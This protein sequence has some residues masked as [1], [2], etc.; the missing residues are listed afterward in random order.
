MPSPNPPMPNNVTQPEHAPM[1]TVSPQAAAALLESQ[2]RRLVETQHRF[3][4]LLIGPS[5]SM[6]TSTALLTA[7]WP[8]MVYSFDPGG[9][10]GSHLRDRIVSPSNPDAP[11]W[12]N[13][14]F[15]QDSPSTPVAFE[16]F[17]NDLRY[18]IAS[19]TFRLFNTL[20]LDSLTTLFHFRLWQRIEVEAKRST[21]FAASDDRPEY[22]PMKR[23]LMNVLSDISAIPCNVIAI[24]HVNPQTR[25]LELPPS[26]RRV[27]EPYFQERWVL[28]WLQ[29]PTGQR[30][31]QLALQCRADGTYEAKTQIGALHWNTYEEPN[32]SALLARAGFVW[33]NLPPPSRALGL[34]PAPPP[35]AEMNPTP[36]KVGT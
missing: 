2:K 14:Q 19:G 17:L 5:G 23:Q 36:P 30:P 11:I 32:L 12:I 15:E 9:T 34:T 3:R 22:K 31:T 1:P 20:V 21:S 16:H 6:K 27:I 25:E 10:S 29:D 7:P 8:I 13:T 35:S 24:I 33:P 28:R 18:H 26:A 4:A